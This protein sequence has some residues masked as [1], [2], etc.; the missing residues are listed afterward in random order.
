LCNVYKASWAGSGTQYR[1]AFT[2]V[3]GIATGNVYTRTQSSDLL[4][5]SNVQPTLPLGC[6]YQ[7][8]ITNIYSLQNGAGETEVVEVQSLGS[9]NL[10]LQQAPVTAVRLADRCENGPRFRSGIVYSLPWVCGVNNWKWEFTLVDAGL[11]PIGLPIV[12]Y[13]NASSNGLNL[14]TVAALQAGQTYAVRTAP[15]FSWG[16]AQFG[17]TQYI[18]ILGSVSSMTNKPA[19]ELNKMRMEENISVAVYPNPTQANNIQ[20]QISGIEIQS[21]V[22]FRIT[23]EL[24]QQVHSF[25]KW[26]NNNE[27]YNLSDELKLSPGLYQL[28]A[29]VNNNRSTQRLII[30]N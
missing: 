23:N 13:R 8:Q 2:G 22:V 7:V 27:V 15:S 10:T 21:V 17:P 9:C 16:D 18:C 24:G 11:N 30:L 4:P 12:H 29:M 28:E 19:Q 6:N 14:G 5:L 20:I 26:M 3:S 25:Q 1:F